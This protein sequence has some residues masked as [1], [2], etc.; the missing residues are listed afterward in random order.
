MLLFSLGKYIINL[1]INGLI[2]I[3]IAIARQ[4]TKYGVL[5]SNIN[6]NFEIYNMY[7]YKY[8]QYS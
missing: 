7:L 5:L 2:M 8:V 6:G 4:I 3:V 1:F